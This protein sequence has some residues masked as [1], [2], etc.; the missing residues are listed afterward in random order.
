MDVSQPFPHFYIISSKYQEMK[1]TLL[2]RGA[3]I[4]L[5]AAS[6]TNEA[7]AQPGRQ[8]RTAPPQIQTA[9]NIQPPE[10]FGNIPARMD[11]LSGERELQPPRRPEHFYTPGKNDS[12]SPIDYEHVRWDDALYMQ[13]VW[14]ELDLREKMNQTF[15][16]DGVDEKGNSQL[17]INVLLRAINTREVEAFADD[18]FSEPISKD[19]IAD[20]TKGKLDTIPKYRVDQIDVIDSFIITRASFDP[21]SVTKLRIMEEWVFDREGSRL[22]SRILGIAALKTQY[23]PDGRERGQSVL[24]WVFYPDLR[25]TLANSRVYNPKNMGNGKM[26]WDELFQ[27]RMFSSYIIKSTLDNASNKNIRAYIKDPKLALLEGENIREKIFN[28]E[29][30]QWSY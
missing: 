22:F 20:I 26:T 15:R 17:F 27:S 18:R 25:P 8:R 1:H 5:I 9:V 11:T 6:L 2:I 29:Q 24:F 12:I 4:L 21:K 30:D 3:A 19:R 23:L 28:Y 16:Y 14:R 13:K 10:T 7:T